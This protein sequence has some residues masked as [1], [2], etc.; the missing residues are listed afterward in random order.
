[1]LIEDTTFE[2]FTNLLKAVAD[3][4]R[5]RILF[6][7]RHGGE[8]SVNEI[9]K[10]LELAQPTTSQHLRILKEAGALTSRKDGQQVLYN[11]E[12][13]PVCDAL[14]DFLVLFQQQTK[15]AMRS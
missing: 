9:A 10:Q 1:M 12:S 4:T 14:M 15:K 8:H 13:I 5:R 2:L 11:I 3:P 7:L 6:L